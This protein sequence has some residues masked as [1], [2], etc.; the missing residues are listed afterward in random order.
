M[1][2]HA[3]RRIARHSVGSKDLDASLPKHSAT[4]ASSWM[5]DRSQYI[6]SIMPHACTPLGHV[7]NLIQIDD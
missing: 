1:S 6:L 2:Q 4:N 3:E 5:G 7:E